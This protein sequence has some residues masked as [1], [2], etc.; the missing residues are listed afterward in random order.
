MIG[1]L[2][3]CPDPWAIQSPPI[4]VFLTYCIFL[5]SCLSPRKKFVICCMLLPSKI[6]CPGSTSKVR[7]SEG[8]SG[9]TQRSLSRALSLPFLPR[10]SSGPASPSKHIYLDSGYSQ[11]SGGN[12]C[13]QCIFCSLVTDWN[14][15]QFGGSFQLLKPFCSLFGEWQHEMSISTGVIS[16]RD[17]LLDMCD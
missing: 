3:C 16:N 15:C 10:I 4:G 17:M 13:Q 7:S 11:K 1:L 2:N 5:S 9:Q 14:L 6:F 12:K 8:S